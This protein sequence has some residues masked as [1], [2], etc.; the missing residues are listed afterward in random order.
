MLD[1]I[2]LAIGLAGFGLGAYWDLKTTEF[3]D[4]L[5]YSIIILSLCVRSV[6]SFVTGDWMI[7]TSSIFIGLAFLAIGLLLYFARQWG[8]GDAWLLGAM[9]FLLPEQL[10]FGVATALPFPLAMLFNFLL[11]SLV[12]LIAYSVY[13]GLRHRSVNSKYVQ[14]LKEHKIKLISMVAFFFVFSWSF[15]F[16][17]TTMPSASANPVSMAQFIFLPFLLTFVLLFSYYAKVVEKHLF[18]K[19]V[20][21]SELREGD[22]ALDGRWK[23]LNKKD[24]AALRKKSKHVWIKEGVRF[25]PVFVITIVI[26]IFCGDLIFLFV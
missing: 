19:K 2:L 20:R 23:G 1:I 18:K 11:V 25:A 17:M 6:F 15:A 7:L 5:P 10:E 21:T 8:D 14:H 12:Y 4:W 16:F 3:P 22:V 24:I 13:L 9:G 26:T